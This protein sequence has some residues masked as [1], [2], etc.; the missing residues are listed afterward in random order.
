[1]YEIHNKRTGQVPE[2]AVYVGRPSIWGNPFVV[3]KNG[4]KKGEG[5]RLFE[6][7]IKTQPLLIAKAKQELRGKDL[8]CWCHPSPCHATV[9]IKIANS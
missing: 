9:W 6:D 7:W 3:G 5:V 8:V 2:N 4:I 1:M